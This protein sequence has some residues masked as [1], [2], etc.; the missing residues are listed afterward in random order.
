MT[1]EKWT[2]N[3]WEGKSDEAQSRQCDTHLT[4]SFADI[5]SASAASGSSG[6]QQAAMVKILVLLSSDNCPCLA[7]LWMRATRD[8]CPFIYGDKDRG[9]KRERRRRQKKILW[10]SQWEAYRLRST[11]LSQGI[12]HNKQ[13]DTIH[14]LPTNLFYKLQETLITEDYQDVL[15]RFP[16]CVGLGGVDQTPR[17]DPPDGQ[18]RPFSREQCYEGFILECSVSMY[19]KEGRKEGR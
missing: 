3:C 12:E 15:G 9:R 7:L 19:E 10:E 1:N 17:T 2:V 16:H 8:L 5:R 11:Q 14:T 4:S 18:G 6:W 13:I